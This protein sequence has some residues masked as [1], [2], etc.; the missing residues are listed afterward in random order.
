[1][2][3]FRYYSYLLID[4]NQIDYPRMDSIVK[5][6][7]KIIGDPA[8]ISDREIYF[9]SNFD[10]EHHQYFTVANAW[11]SNPPSDGQKNPMIE[12][13]TF[14]KPSMDYLKSSELSTNKKQKTQSTNRTY[15]GIGKLRY[16]P[17]NQID[18]QLISKLP[19]I[20]V[21]LLQVHQMEKLRHQ[22]ARNVPFNLVLFIVL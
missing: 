1:M 19:S 15:C 21:R 9:R 5:R 2:I 3:T 12:L 16:A 11:F 18:F 4:S 7:N 14:E 13:E 8:K 10:Y 20:L 6:K 22:L 17:L